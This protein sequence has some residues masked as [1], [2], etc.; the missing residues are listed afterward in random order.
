VEIEIELA[1]AT[2]HVAGGVAL[3]GLVTDY[4]LGRELFACRYRDQSKHQGEHQ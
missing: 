2:E 1:A 4:V 3:G